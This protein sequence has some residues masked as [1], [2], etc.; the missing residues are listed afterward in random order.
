ME[1][2]TFTY[3]SENSVVNVTLLFPIQSDKKAE[4]AFEDMLKRMYLNK[5]EKQALEEID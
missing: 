3:T 5:G 1:S 4:S 2:R